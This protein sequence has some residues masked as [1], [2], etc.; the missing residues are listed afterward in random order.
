MQISDAARHVGVA[1]HVLR[2]WEEVGV[3]RPCRTASGH[4]VYDDELVAQ[5][6]L[7][8]ICRRAGLSLAELATLAS[9]DL[10]DRAALIVTKRREIARER[11]A[12]DRADS[13]LAH[14]LECRHPVVTDCPDCTDFAR[15]G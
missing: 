15:T 13:F 10:Q 7:V 11:E 6:R 5:A 4:R 12:L 14:T 2:H 9:S 8:R 3:L 1:A